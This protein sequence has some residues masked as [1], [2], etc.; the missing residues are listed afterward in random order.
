MT[1]INVHGN[2]RQVKLLEGISNTLLVAGGGVFA[3]LQVGV[4]DQ[5]GEGIR[6][7]NEGNG[8]VGVLLEDGDDGCEYD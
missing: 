1:G 5:V 7:D 2:I 8:S 3:G 4:G 6:L